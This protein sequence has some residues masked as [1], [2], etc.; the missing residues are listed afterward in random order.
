MSG[1]GF[2]EEAGGPAASPLQPR[3]A[4]LEALV[5]HIE[6]DTADIK[7]E[8]RTMHANARG[9]VRLLFGAIISVA[10]GLAAII[11]E[12]FHWF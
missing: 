10:L 8:M 9:D 3:V 12:G 2:G 6:R 4:K 7:A 5:E 1:G 11:V